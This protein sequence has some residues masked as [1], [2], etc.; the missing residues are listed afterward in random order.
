[1]DIGEEN[2]EEYYINLKIALLMLM[3]EAKRFSLIDKS[4]MKIMQ[5][6]HETTN[7]IICCT[8]DDTL[9]Q[10]LPHLMEQLELCQK[11]LSGYVKSVLMM[12]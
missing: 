8:G 3:Q 11:S 10:L 2:T 6:A 4:W 5:K 9:M 7:V 1:M 12:M